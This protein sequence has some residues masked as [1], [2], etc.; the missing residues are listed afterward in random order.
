MFITQENLTELTNKVDNAHLTSEQAL[1]LY[2]A[3][4]RSA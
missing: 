3:P 2:C 1:N 4:A